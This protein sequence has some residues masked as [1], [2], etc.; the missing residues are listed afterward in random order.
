MLKIFWLQ[1]QKRREYSEDLGVDEKIILKWIVRKWL[2]KF[3]LNLTGPP[4]VAVC[5]EK[6]DEFVRFHERRK[7]LDQLIN[8]QLLKNNYTP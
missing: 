2:G 7:L 6:C 8:C 1:S 5:F 3:R 4:S